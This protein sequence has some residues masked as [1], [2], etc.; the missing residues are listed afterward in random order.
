MQTGHHFTLVTTLTLAD[1][2]QHTR[3]GLS[4]SLQDVFGG[5]LVRAWSTKAY[6][7]AD[8]KISSLGAVEVS[9]GD[10]SLHET[11]SDKGVRKLRAIVTDG[12]ITYDLAVTADAVLRDWQRSGLRA[13]RAQLARSRKLHLRIGLSRPFSGRPD[14]CYAQINGIYCL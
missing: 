10:V 3:A 14:E 1:V 4:A 7:A 9:P 2:V 13:V 11:I 6:V 5:N 12:Q 8:L